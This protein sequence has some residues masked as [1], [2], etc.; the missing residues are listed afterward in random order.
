M[1]AVI[2]AESIAELDKT[3]EPGASARRDQ[4][5]RRMTDLLVANAERLNASQIGIFGGVF[6]RLLFAAQRTIRFESAA[7]ITKLMRPHVTNSSLAT[8]RTGS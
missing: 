5:L 6:A 2:S 4:V 3:V 1:T 8:A 7:D